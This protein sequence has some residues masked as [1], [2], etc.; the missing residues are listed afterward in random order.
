MFEPIVI[1]THS[2]YTEFG[3]RAC[4]KAEAAP[5]VVQRRIL[6]K[7]ARLRSLHAFLI[8]IKFISRY[9]N[10]RFKHLKLGSFDL[11][12]RPNKALEVKSV[13]SYGKNWVKNQQRMSATSNLE[14]YRATVEGRVVVDM[15]RSITIAHNLST[16]T[17]AECSQVRN[18]VQ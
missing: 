9:L 8:P 13:V 17:L 5:L 10:E 7:H 16:F 2:A 14:T 3:R 6:L 15:L 12:R 1:S 4:R 11:G 18:Y